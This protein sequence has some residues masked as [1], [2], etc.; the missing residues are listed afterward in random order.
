MNERAAEDKGALCEADVSLSEEMAS[1]GRRGGEHRAS[2]TRPTSR[3][4][5]PRDRL[6]YLPNGE[7]ECG[8]EHQQGQSEPRGRGFP[9]AAERLFHASI[10]LLPWVQEAIT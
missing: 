4:F 9:V 7:D 8:P 1:F 2:R 3:G 10:P 6:S 5:T